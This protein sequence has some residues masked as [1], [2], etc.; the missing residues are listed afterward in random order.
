MA[1]R[2]VFMRLGLDWLLHVDSDEL[3]EP[4]SCLLSRFELKPNL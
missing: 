1:Q 3:W 2:N 4:E